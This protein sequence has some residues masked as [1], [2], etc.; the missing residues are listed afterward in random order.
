MHAGLVVAFD[1]AQKLV[2]AGLQH[3]GH[4]AV[5]ARFEIGD[6]AQ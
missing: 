3:G 4:L 2:G 1:V 6:L 5:V